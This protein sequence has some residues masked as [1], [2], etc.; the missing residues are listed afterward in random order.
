MKN[1]GIFLTGA[2]TGAAIGVL[3]APNSGEKT[4]KLISKEVDNTMHDWEKTLAK[5]TKEMKSEY[6][7]K[8]QDLSK[9]GKEWVSEAKDAVKLN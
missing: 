7:K 4:R 1:I 9:Q 3:L 8:I 5:T 6:N 2:I